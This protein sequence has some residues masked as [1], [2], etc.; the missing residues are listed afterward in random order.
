MARKEV[1]GRLP[2][3]YQRLGLKYEFLDGVHMGLNV[4]FNDFSRANNLEF[5]VG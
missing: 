1:K 2:K 3:L 4:R 5:N